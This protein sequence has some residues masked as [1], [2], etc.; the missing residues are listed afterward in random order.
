MRRL[1]AALILPALAA[2]TPAPKGDFRDDS[3]NITSVALFDASRFA[4]VWHVVAAYG[5]EA[6]CG[7]LIETWAPTGPDSFRVTGTACGPRGPRAFL[8]EAQQSG[9]GRFVRTGAAGREDLWVM[10]V[11]EG[12]RVAV[13]GTP[14]GRF[15][16]VLSREPA[17][18]DDLMVAAREILSFNG[19]DPAQL[20]PMRRG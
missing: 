9:P 3:A 18:R 20:R 16:R 19:Y 5:S 17:L 15:A 13:I 2:C 4:D 12:Y 1:I 11:D 6:D 10:W 14:D 8:A 7:P